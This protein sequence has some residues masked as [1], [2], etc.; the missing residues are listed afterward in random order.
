[1]RIVRL[2]D[3]VEIPWKNGGG[4]TREI[5]EARLGEDLLWRLSMA[6]VARGGPF[7][8]FTGL[9]RILTVIDGGGMDL[10]TPAGTLHAA[11][12]APVR[13]DGG[14]SV[15]AHLLDGPLRDLNLMYYPGRVEGDV[16][17]LR[18][19]EQ[20]VLETD[21]TRIYA[22][23]CLSQTVVFAATTPLQRGDTAMIETGQAVLSLAEGGS[24]LL[25]T[26]SLRLQTDASSDETARR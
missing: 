3:L 12:A 21:A 20:H 13:F 15:V 25:I 8:D 24:A 11:F 4:I 19:G 23:H 10:I 1:M 6:D 9:M 2:S 18:G 22:V 14:L 17:I 5:A 7:S 26:L 16:V